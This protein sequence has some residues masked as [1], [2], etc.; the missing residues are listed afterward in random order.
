MLIPV[1]QNITPGEASYIKI[2]KTNGDKPQ[3]NLRNKQFVSNTSLEISGITDDQE[4]LFLYKNN[5]YNLSQL[6]FTIN[7]KSYNSEGLDVQNFSILD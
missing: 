4:V 3:E 7:L 5:N 6:L 2:E 1:P